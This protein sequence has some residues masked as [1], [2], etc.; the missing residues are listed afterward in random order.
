[1]LANVLVLVRMISGTEGEERAVAFVQYVEILALSDSL[2]K[3]LGFI[4]AG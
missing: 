2:E 1:M 4:C 3:S